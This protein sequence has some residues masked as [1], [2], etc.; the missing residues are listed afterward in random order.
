MKSTELGL[1]ITQAARTYL[2]ELVAKKKTQGMGVRMFVQNPG[3][4]QAETCLAYCP[5]EDR[6]EGDLLLEDL[7][8][9]CF[10]EKGSEE[11]LAEAVVDYQQE[12]LG[13]QLTIKAPNTRIRKPGAE[14]SIRERINYLLYTEINP[15]LAQHGGVVYLEGLEERESVAVLRFGGGC[16]GCGL[17][18]VTLK[19]GVERTLKEHVPGLRAI[20]DVTDHSDRSQAYYH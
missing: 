6:V 18:D 15:A 5:T 4:P 2:T 19:Q 12:Q 1:E 8:F 13:G 20:R 17:V 11:F 9:P 10:V 14:A 7:D 16:Q 3:T